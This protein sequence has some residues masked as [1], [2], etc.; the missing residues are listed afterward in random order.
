MRGTVSFGTSLA[1]IAPLSWALVSRSQEAFHAPS[2][3]PRVVTPD[4]CPDN[5]TY[6]G[7][8]EVVEDGRG[9]WEMRTREWSFNNDASIL[10]IDNV[11]A[12]TG[13]SKLTIQPRGAGFSYA[14]FPAVD[15]VFDSARDTYQFIQSFIKLFP[16]YASNPWAVNSLSYGGH[17]APVYG[18]YIQHMNAKILGKLSLWEDTWSTP[19]DL[20]RYS[21]LNL[22]SI[23]V[24]NGWINGRVQYRSWVDFACGGAED[25]GIPQLAQEG[26]CRWAQDR[27]TGGEKLMD[28]CE[29]SVACAAAGQYSSTVASFPYTMTGLNPYDYRI[30]SPYDERGV[31]AY[32][33]NASVQAVLG[34]IGKSSDKPLSWEAHSAR[35]WHAYVY[36]GDWDVQTDVF[37][38]RLLRSG[39]SVLKYE[40]MVDFICNYLGVREIMAKLPNYERQATFNK[41]NL[42]DWAVGGGNKSCGAYKCLAGR[43]EREGNLC[44]VE[45]E[46]AGHVLSLDKPR[47]GSLMISQWL[48]KHTLGSQKL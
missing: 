25:R 44:Y 10:M 33:N 26:D 48:H 23:S 11:S 20:E 6:A 4:L 8:C 18:S 43:H 24:G 17:Y 3:S 45:I 41:L 37:F 31:I 36:S 42:S 5:T 9:G 12:S 35:V 1:S 16:E 29:G 27:L 38:E 30:S 34:V 13:M 22:T 21:P 28:S 14:E 32:F 2:S 46:G 47:E 7:P 39:V 40:G 19:S 15:S